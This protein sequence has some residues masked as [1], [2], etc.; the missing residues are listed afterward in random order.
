MLHCC[1][2][3][4]QF[5]G[6]QSGTGSQETVVLLSVI[7]FSDT[8]W[9]VTSILPS[10][11]NSMNL[12][13]FSTS[14]HFLS[15]KESPVCCIFKHSDVGSKWWLVSFKK[16]NYKMSCNFYDTTNSLRFMFNLDKI[17][18]LIFM[19]MCLLKFDKVKLNSLRALNTPP[20]PH[21]SGVWKSNLL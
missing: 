20:P 11:P 12:G 6:L 4:R 21:Y 3:L 19:Y 14:L 15:S 7:P 9:S 18:F 17:S 10:H 13:P 2:D 16:T 5:T 1:H 8:F